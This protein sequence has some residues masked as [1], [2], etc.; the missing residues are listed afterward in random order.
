MIK[1]IR[2]SFLKRFIIIFI[3]LFALLVLLPFI[4]EQAVYLFS[5]GIVPGSNS[6]IVFKDYVA[7]HEIFNIFFNILKKIINFM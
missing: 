1:N 2:S 7:D 3:I 6:I 5:E 4:V